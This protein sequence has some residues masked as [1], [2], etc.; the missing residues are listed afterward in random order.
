MSAV[1][2]TRSR[3]ARSELPPLHNGDR[4]TQPEFHRRYEAYPEDVKFELIGGTVYMGSPLRET[5]SDYE[6][7]LGFVFELYRR[8]TPG[9]KAIHGAT[10]ILGAE[11]EPQPDLGLRILEEYGGRSRLTRK[12]YIE[13]PPEL[14]AEISHSTVAIDL[15]QKKADYQKAGVQE[16]LVVCVD[17]RL[18]FW[19]DFQK[20]QS[21]VGNAQG[22]YQSRVFPGL[23]LQAPALLALNSS[24]VE[25]VARQGLA[26]PEHAAFVE[27][28]RAARRK[29]VPKRAR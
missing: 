19:F 6:G 11:S 13:G 10:T 5:H 14:L 16:Y 7:E 1:S 2:R 8:A 26:N 21:I 24:R 27:R 15:H 18:L 17:E 22:I 9:V 12:K 29:R 20:R 4:L 3:T 28:L 25:D 23:W